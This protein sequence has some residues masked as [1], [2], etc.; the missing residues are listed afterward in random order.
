MFTPVVA[1]ARAEGLAMRGY[2]SMCFGDPWEGDVPIEQVVEVVGRLLDLGFTGL[3]LGDTIG[4][5]T[6]GHVTALIGALRATGADIGA[7]AVHFHDTYGR[8]S[9]TRSPRSTAESRRS[10]P[11]P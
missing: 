2:V 9:P 5:A 10:T 8:R 11:R 7:H 4:V 6:P 1:R 3:S